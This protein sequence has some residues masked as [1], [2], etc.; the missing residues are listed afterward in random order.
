MRMSYGFSSL[1][2]MDQNY[3][4]DRK[5]KT[6]YLVINSSGEMQK[7]KTFCHN[8]YKFITKEWK[9]GYDTEGRESGMIG[10]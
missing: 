3:L 1:C 9:I 10:T 2:F 4:I 8:G 7:S 6:Y 5:K